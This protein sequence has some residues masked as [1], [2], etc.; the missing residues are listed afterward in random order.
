MN[1]DDKKINEKKEKKIISISS[2][3]YDA[4]TLTKDLIISILSMP[5]DKRALSQK[6]MLNFFCM[7][8]SK[9]PQKFIKEHIDKSSYNNIINLSE[10]SFSYK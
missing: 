2:L 10:P 3:E 4:R 8:I 7:N 5:M 6:M 9:L 1:L